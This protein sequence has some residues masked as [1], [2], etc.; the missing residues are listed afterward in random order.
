MVRCTACHFLAQMKG[1]W[2]DAIVS[3]QCCVFMPTWCVLW[4]KL[5]CTDDF[6]ALSHL[7][8]WVTDIYFNLQKNVL[9]QQEV[10][11]LLQTFSSGRLI[12][13]WCSGACGIDSKRFDALMCFLID[14]GQSSSVTQRNT[15]CDSQ[16]TLSKIHTLSFC[17]H[18]GR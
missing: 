15:T 14:F 16:T 13:V 1:M 17:P 3:L 18:H 4:G 9:K 6:H 2:G 11:D 7:Q 12:H 8:K 5:I 10:V